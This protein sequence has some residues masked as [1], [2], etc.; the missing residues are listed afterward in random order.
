MNTAKPTIDPALLDLL[1]H[2]PPMLLL[3][4]L[5]HVDAQ[6]SSARVDIHPEVP[7]FEPDRGV[8]SWIGIEYMGQTAALIAGHQSSQKPSE[9]KRLGLLLG[10]RTYKTRSA[11]F[12]PASSLMIYCEQSALVGEELAT[13][14]CTI[15]CEGEDS[16]IASANLSVLR[17]P[18]ADC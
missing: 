15:S 9:Q 12:K 2:R 17:R 14:A 11:Y 1:P 6:S 13:F 10:T 4:Q 18:L 5:E 8:P 3:H 7:F 16:P